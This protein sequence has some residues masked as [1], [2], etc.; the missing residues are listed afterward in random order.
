MEQAN[1]RETVK[2]IVTDLGEVASL[3]PVQPQQLEAQARILDRLG[4]ELAEAAS[5]LRRSAPGGAARLGNHPAT[6]GRP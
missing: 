1:A 4:E 5:M 6:A 3:L 2:A